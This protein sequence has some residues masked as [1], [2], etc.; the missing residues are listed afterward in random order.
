MDQAEAVATKFLI[1][2]GEAPPAVMICLGESLRHPAVIPLPWESPAQ[3]AM[4]LDAL[5]VMFADIGVTAYAL[6][7]ECWMATYPRGPGDPPLDE[8]PDVMPRDKP[9]RIDALVLVGAEKG[10]PA[11]FR[12]WQVIKTSPVTLKRLDGRDG[13][14]RPARRAAGKAAR[15]LTFQPSGM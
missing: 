2:N 5:K 4:M 8:W 3:K 7:S 13:R 11:V 15:Q 14:R 9:D 10:K 1:A 12:A 6:W